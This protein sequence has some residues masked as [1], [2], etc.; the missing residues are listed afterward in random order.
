MVEFAGEKPH[1]SFEG[2]NSTYLCLNIQEVTV[3]SDLSG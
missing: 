3:E 1:P 2:S